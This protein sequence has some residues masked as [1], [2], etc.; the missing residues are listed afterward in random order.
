MAIWS[1]PLARL[2][3]ANDHPLRSTSAM[4]DASFLNPLVSLVQQTFT[5]SFT[6]TTTNNTSYDNDAFGAASSPYLASSP[7]LPI[8]VPALPSNF[9]CPKGGEGYGPYSTVRQ[10]DLTPCF[11]SLILTIPLGLLLVV[12][13]GSIGWLA[14]KG[15]RRI[16]GGWSSKILHWKLVSGKRSIRK[17]RIV[18]IVLA[19]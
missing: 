18:L 6:T 3:I 16:R 11:E 14:R 1:I 10:M 7:S 17:G 4:E 5:S 15:E 12:G 8:P 9:L 2:M 13:S 19:C